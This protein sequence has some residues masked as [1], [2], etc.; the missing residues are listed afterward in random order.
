[1]SPGRS[2]DTMGLIYMSKYSITAKNYIV[3]R[4][5]QNYFRISKT[6]VRFNGEHQ[7]LHKIQHV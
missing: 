4:L 3:T 7:N 1:M 5:F 6:L 2:T